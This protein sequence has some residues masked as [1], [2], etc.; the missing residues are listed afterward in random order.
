M[1]MLCIR[2]YA[3]AFVRVEYPY[4]HIYTKTNSHWRA[5]EITLGGAGKQ[6][7]NTSQFRL[8]HG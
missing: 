4:V 2:A 1:F 7:L 3:H 8:S 6:S 5:N